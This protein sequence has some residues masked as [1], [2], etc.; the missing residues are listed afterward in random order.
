M[1]D[2]KNLI[3]LVSKLVIG[4]QTPNTDINVCKLGVSY[5][6]SHQISWH[7]P[8]IKQSINS[9]IQIK[10]ISQLIHPNKMVLI[11]YVTCKMGIRRQTQ[12]ATL[13][14]AHMTTWRPTTS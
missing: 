11:L 3:C 7:P 12:Q 1:L 9:I 8:S 2:V 4:R 13:S 5:L 6:S 14:K 10:Y